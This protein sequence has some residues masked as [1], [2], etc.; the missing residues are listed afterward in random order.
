MTNEELVLLIQDGVDVQENMG[1]LYK[2][3]QGFIRNTCLPFSERVDLDDLMQE[4]YFG[5]IDA[6]RGFDSTL[7]FTFLSYAKWKIRRY[8]L[9]YIKTNGNIKRIPEYMQDRIRKYK[10]LIQ[11]FG[12]VPD[13]KTTLERMKLTKEQYELMVL[14]MFQKNVVCIDEPLSSD[15]LSYADIVADGSDI[16]GDYVLKEACKELWEILERVLD[17]RKKNILVKHFKEE[18]SIKDI[19]KEEGVTVQRVYSLE[20]I[21]LGELKKIDAVILKAEEFGYN[22]QIAYSGKHTSTEYL[23]IKHVEL[24]REYQRLKEDFGL[25]LSDVR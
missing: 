22:S 1:I 13:E 2:Q 11:E 6:V 8:C 5:L 19:A 3:N 18:R 14:T 23:A 17:K 25:V 10:E 20:Q 7:G 15:G 21:A 12:C 24:E 4:A 16:E 9:K